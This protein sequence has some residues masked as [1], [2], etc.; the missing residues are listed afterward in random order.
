[1]GYYR[2]ERCDREPDHFYDDECVC[3]IVRKIVTSQDKVKK[4]DCTN[5]CDILNKQMPDRE[6]RPVKTTVP[7]ML[8]CSATCDPFIGNGV[9]KAPATRS[10]KAFFGSIE[11]PVFRA[12]T[13]VSDCCVKL[14][15]L[16]P[17]SNECEV[18]PANTNNV[19]SISR[20]FPE[21][22]PV[23]NFIAT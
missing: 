3:H 5:H 21:D 9:F 1:M 7:F 19:S 13:F 23:T 22:T 16:L 8:Y 6:K 14:E 10:R 18:R 20:F 17:V 15:L 4:K 12:I 11:T 2:R